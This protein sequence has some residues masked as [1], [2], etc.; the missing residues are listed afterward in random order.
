MNFVFFIWIFTLLL[1]FFDFSFFLSFNR[2]FDEEKN[3]FFFW[4]NLFFYYQNVIR[5][6]LLLKKRIFFVNKSFDPHQDYYR[7]LVFGVLTS[8]HHHFVKVFLKQNSNTVH[9]FLNWKFF[10]SNKN[11]FSHFHWSCM[12]SFSTKKNSCFFF[13]DFLADDDDKSIIQFI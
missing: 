3:E 5:L 6:L 2:I 9:N 4:L 12:N 7:C 1:L 10:F 13:W 8:G 11:P